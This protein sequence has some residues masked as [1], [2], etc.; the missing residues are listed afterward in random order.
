MFIV[1]S[2]Q[3]ERTSECE[4]TK[5]NNLHLKTSFQQ[6]KFKTQVFY[7]GEIFMK[8]NIIRH[9]QD[10]WACKKTLTDFSSRAQFSDTNKFHVICWH[11]RMLHFTNLSIYSHR[12]FC[13]NTA[14]IMLHCTS[15]AH[16]H[17]LPHYFTPAEASNV[18]LT[19]SKKNSVLEK[20]FTKSLK[21]NILRNTPFWNTGRNVPHDL[22]WIK[23]D[24]GLS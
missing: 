10:C 2:K 22:P 16:L 19:V 12:L 21:R 18:L 8:A 6:K 23:A 7:L 5:T 14:R 17:A 11:R 13:S 9:L 20:A 24:E 1:L 15:K 3:D 4:Q